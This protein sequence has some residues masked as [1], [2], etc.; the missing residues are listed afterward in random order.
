MALR[1][2]SGALR[3]IA[4]G[5]TLRRLTSKIAL[6]LTGSRIQNVLEP[7]QVGVRTSHGTEGI[8][9]AARQWM[10]RH[11]DNPNKVMVLT[12]IENAFNSVDRSAVLQA[13]RESFSEIAPWT[14]LCYSS[15]SSLVIG[16]STIDS[17]RGVQQGDPLGPALFAL[18]IHPVRLKARRLTTSAF[19]GS[20]DLS[21]FFLDDGVLAGDAPVIRSFLRHLIAGFAS[22]GLEIALDKPEV[23]AACS[24]SQSFS[25][26]DFPGCSWNSSRNFKLL[27]AAIGDR[28][29]CEHL[30]SKR[31][32]KASPSSCNRQV[33]GCSRGLHSLPLLHRMG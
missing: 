25:P 30:L 3:P 26:E 17:T 32:A 11:S 13:V 5:E 14:D 15:P 27:G 4:D 21:P 10:N 7:I 23:L 33:R 2:P 9:H 20:V 6:E 31:V 12:D 24:S 1:K 19:P 16:D 18:A 8:V 28:K 22:I 29:W